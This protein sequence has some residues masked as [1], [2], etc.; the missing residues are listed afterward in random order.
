VSHLQLGN[1]HRKARKPHRCC[2]C[3]RKIL[4]GEQYWH[5]RGISEGDPVSENT[6][7]ACESLRNDVYNAWPTCERTEGFIFGEL[8]DYCDGEPFLSRWKAIRESAK[9]QREL[10]AVRA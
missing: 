3:W 9:A 7:E 6:C 1:E 8:G 5:Y 4:P 2:E 10:E